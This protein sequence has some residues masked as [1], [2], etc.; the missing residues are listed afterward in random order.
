M[1]HKNQK[2]RRGEPKVDE[3]HILY[4]HH[5]WNSVGRWGKLLR[6][7]PYYKKIIPIATLHGSIH[8]R[9]PLIAPPIYEATERAIEQHTITVRFDTVEQ[10]IDFFLAQ[11][12]AC[13]ECQK[14][15][16]TVL[17]LQQQ[18]KIVANYYAKHSSSKH[19]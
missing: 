12:D 16:D 17:A 10:R 3:H 5:E 19:H 11:L 4:T 7:H 8:H 2:Q 13:K 18:R 9:L 15:S 6:N 14:Y 1:S